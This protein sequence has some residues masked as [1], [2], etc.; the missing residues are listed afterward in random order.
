LTYH[1]IAVGSPSNLK[2]N[3]GTIQRINNNEGLKMV[4]IPKKISAGAKKQLV[5]ELLKEIK[6]V[7][8][9]HGFIIEPYNNTREI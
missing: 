4:F 1:I 5:D 7:F 3:H 9:R 2:L 8:E 6:V